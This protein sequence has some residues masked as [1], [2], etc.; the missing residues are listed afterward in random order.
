MAN[1][2]KRRQIGRNISGSAIFICIFILAGLVGGVE[3]NAT[4][5]IT[6]ILWAIPVIL[7]LA[8]SAYIFDLTGGFD[9]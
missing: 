5:I 2:A 6:A 4:S 7:V 3:T 9:K 1:Y 8:F